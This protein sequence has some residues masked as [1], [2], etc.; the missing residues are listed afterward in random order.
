MVSSIKRAAEHPMHWH[1]IK[2]QV[3]NYAIYKYE[4]KKKRVYK[5]MI[6]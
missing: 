3:V 5:V 1:D 2:H 6:R 4:K